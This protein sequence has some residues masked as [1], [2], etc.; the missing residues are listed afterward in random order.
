MN[1][2]SVKLSA[3]NI[4]RLTLF[5][6]AILIFSSEAYCAGYVGT[7][8]IRYLQ[9]AYTGWIIITNGTAENPD[10]CSKNIIYIDSNA[11]QFKDIFSFLLTAY[12]AAK[13]V[14]IYVNGCNPQGYKLFSFVGSTWNTK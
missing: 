11:S 6:V 7:G 13:P 2:K 3:G 14:N 12:T 1:K 4:F 8:T 10:A 9:N 5:S